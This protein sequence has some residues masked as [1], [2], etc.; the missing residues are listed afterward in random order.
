MALDQSA[1]RWRLDEVVTNIGKPSELNYLVRLP[2]SIS[3]DDMITAIRAQAGDTISGADIQ[4]AEAAEP[5]PG[6]KA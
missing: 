4:L 1:R 5:V 2:K 3:K 6:G